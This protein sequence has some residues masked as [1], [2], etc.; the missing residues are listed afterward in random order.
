M[1]VI[2]SK[3]LF[4]APWFFYVILFKSNGLKKTTI[5]DSIV[6]IFLIADNSNWVLHHVIIDVE[7]VN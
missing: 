7:F 2:W 4:R 6:L 1:I 3:P 5:T